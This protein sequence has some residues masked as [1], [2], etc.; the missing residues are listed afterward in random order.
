MRKN[1][2][3]IIKLIEKSNELIAEVYFLEKEKK[4]QT[5]TVDAYIKKF[6]KTQRVWVRQDL[7]HL[8][9]EE[10][11]RGLENGIRR[12]AIRIKSLLF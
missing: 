12:E 4:S 10:Y 2:E 8:L 1:I 6:R 7:L 5:L 3:E 9:S 11:R